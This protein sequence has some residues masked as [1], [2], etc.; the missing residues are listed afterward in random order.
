MN[1]QDMIM[2][3][4][5]KDNLNI[6]LKSACLALIRKAKYLNNEDGDVF[7]TFEE[8]KYED[9]ARLITFGNGKILGS[10]LLKDA[11]KIRKKGDN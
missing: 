4:Y 10:T 1:A 9:L 11:T 5:L 7:M 8:K 6:S 3:K 2:D